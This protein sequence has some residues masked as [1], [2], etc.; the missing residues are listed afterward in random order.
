MYALAENRTTSGHIISCEWHHSVYQY[1]NNG[2]ISACLS[3][4]QDVTERL[5]TEKK[6]GKLA[7]QLGAILNATGDAL[8][9]INNLRRIILW[10]PAA[11]KLFG[12]LASE[13]MG[14]EIE[15]LFPAEFQESQ[16]EKFRQFLEHK[17]HYLDC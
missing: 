14:R 12:W 16:T 6:L 9:G 3:L 5:S 2:E 10:N 8:V 4:G 17:L 15:I 11:E 1:D 7:G 13:V